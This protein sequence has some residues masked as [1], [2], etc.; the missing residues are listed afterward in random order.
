MSILAD[1]N[2]TIKSLG[3]PIETGV[4]HD[5]A[6]DKYIVIVPLSDSFILHADNT[7]ECDIQEAR[8]S[9]YAQGSYTKEKNAIIRALLNADFT[10]T[11]RRYIGYE[12]QTGYFH[13]NVDVAK[14]YKLEV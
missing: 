13:Y 2:T 6:P 3:I 5:D 7:P 11:D 10:I 9:L 12:T 4:F 8:I 14:H 1:I